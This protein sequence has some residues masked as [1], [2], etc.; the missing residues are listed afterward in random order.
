MKAKVLKFLVSFL[1]ALNNM[2]WTIAHDAMTAACVWLVMKYVVEFEIN[3]VPLV[4]LVYI[5]GILTRSAATHFKVPP[6][7]VYGYKQFN[8][9]HYIYAA[10]TH[11]FKKDLHIQAAL[12]EKI[13][14]KCSG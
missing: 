9:H 1:V 14:K 5:F 13:R 11:E 8:G 6:I 7:P 3:Y 12:E 4:G 10:S 2:F